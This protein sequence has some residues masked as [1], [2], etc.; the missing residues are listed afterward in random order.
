MRSF[1][2]ACLVVSSAFPDLILR[3]PCDRADVG[4][5][6]PAPSALRA[7]GWL[8]AA[9]SAAYVPPVNLANSSRIDSL[10]RAGNLYL[11]AQD[12]IA[13]ALENNIDI[14]VQRYGPL[15]AREVLRRAEGGGLLRNVGQGVAAGPTSVSLTG[16]SVNTN[17][18][19]ATA[20]AAAST[21]AAASSLSSGR[22]FL[23]S[24]R[25]F[26]A[27]RTSS[28]PPRRRATPF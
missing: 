13:L 18:A 6:R 1:A 7:L 24:I 23:L 28:T 11:S 4:Q 10:I 17:G 21:R 25:P 8:T 27:L 5:N 22:V 12:V 14:E 3:A 20:A 19:P 16:V 26:P 2:V 15:L 9:V